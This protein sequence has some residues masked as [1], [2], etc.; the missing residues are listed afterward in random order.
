MTHR[1]VL[2]CCLAVAWSEP[3]T[4]I[5]NEDSNSVSWP[6]TG[7]I[8]AIESSDGCCPAFVTVG[9]E[10]S[11]YFS[12]LS[13]PIGPG[14]FFGYGIFFEEGPLFSGSDPAAWV[15]ERG[16]GAPDRLRSV[17]TA[18]GLLEDVIQLPDLYCCNFTLELL[19][20]D[21]DGVAFDGLIYPP[22]PDLPPVFAP[23]PALFETRRIRLLWDFIDSPESA[24][25]DVR[26][27]SFPIPEPGAGGLLGAG[28]GIIAFARRRWRL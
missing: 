11:G 26:I 5:Y 7:T 24:W 8:E 22:D 25:I 16:P 28:L 12:F 13:A 4:A 17:G 14:G 27:D 18:I 2:V 3:A 23:N 6:F 21:D 10:A 15:I 20:I 19:L 1:L 9:E